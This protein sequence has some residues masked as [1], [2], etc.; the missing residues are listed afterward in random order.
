MPLTKNS[1]VLPG[2]ADTEVSVARD[3]NCTV[4]SLRG[5]HDITTVDDLAAAIAR[6]IAQGDSDVIVD[7]SGV[8]FLTA[9]TIGAIV[10]A[11]HLLQ[12]RSRALVVRAPSRCAQRVLDICGLAALI[13]PVSAPATP[14]AV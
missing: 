9:A 5:E 10:R 8:E 12:S 4:V 11:R 6:E 7:L 1:S 3:V 2:R 13:E 14:P